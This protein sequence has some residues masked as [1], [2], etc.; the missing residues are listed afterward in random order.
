MTLSD[1]NHI[2]R[3]IYLITLEALDVYTR[4]QSA[5]IIYLQRVKT[6]FRNSKFNRCGG[7]KLMGENAS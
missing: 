6:R 1:G 4:G 5:G 7:S 3:Y 2:S